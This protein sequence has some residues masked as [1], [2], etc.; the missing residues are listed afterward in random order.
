[1][2]HSDYLSGWDETQLQ[3]VLDGCE[4]ESEAANPT[5][6]C[7]SWLTYRWVLYNLSLDLQLDSCC[8]GKGKVDGVQT[9][10]EEIRSD[11]ETIQPPP[12]DTQATI[13]PEAVTNIATLPR[14]ICTGTLIPGD[15]SATTTTGQPATT[16][17]ASETTG[18]ISAAAKMLALS[19]L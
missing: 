11:L 16:T 18:E 10:D 5:A 7:S 17:T 14:G 12:V 13:S 4:N 1:M 3:T 15:N 9:D 2:F 19:V 6:F 8:R